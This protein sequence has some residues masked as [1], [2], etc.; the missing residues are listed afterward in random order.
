MNKV[1][2]FFT[3]S[4][5]LTHCILLNVVILRQE[6]HSCHAGWTNWHNLNGE[7]FGNN[8]EVRNAH[9]FDKAMYLLEPKPTDNLAHVQ[10]N[11]C[12]RIFPAALC[13]TAK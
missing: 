1:K 8:F 9:A 13:L 6:V 4:L 12:T 7:Q 2:L 5:I 10:N 3:F 11:G